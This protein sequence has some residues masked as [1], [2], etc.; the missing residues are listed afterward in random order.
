[1]SDEVSPLATRAGALATSTLANALDDFGLAGQILPT[2]KAVA[3]GFRCAGP[4][5]T[6]RELVG[7]AGAFKSE[8]FRVGA[9]IDAAGAGDVIVVQADG[10]N[11]STWGGMASF[12]A[13]HKGV[14]GL[15]C[16][17]GVRD[18]EEIVGFEFPVYAR[19]LTPTTGRTR[20]KVDAIGEPIVVDGVDVAPGDMIVADGTGVVVLP[21]DKAA[22]II[23]MAEAFDTDDKA[24]IQDLAEGLTFAEAMAKYTRI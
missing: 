12:A 7:A 15:I 23:A 20:L 1:M 5:V 9:M 17:G 14:A 18:L 19:H 8:D 10:A 3:P 16:D 22:E 21:Q 6:V 2:L 24:A 11:I 4:A 13:K